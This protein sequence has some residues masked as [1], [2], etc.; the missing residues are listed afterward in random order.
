MKYII[1]EINTGNKIKF[2]EE[3]I[4][5]VEFDDGFTFITLKNG[6]DYQTVDS[7]FEFKRYL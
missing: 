5:K 1:T 7:N 2:N 3:D 4:K 6:K